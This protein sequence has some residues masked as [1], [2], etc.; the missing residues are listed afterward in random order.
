[1]IEEKKI[2]AI[3][4]LLMSV[5]IAFAQQQIVKD[6]HGRTMQINIPDAPEIMAATGAGYA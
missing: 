6:N 4:I 2:F 1:M 3:I 5:C